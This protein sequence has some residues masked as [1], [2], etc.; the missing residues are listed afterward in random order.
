MGL[1][2]RFQACWPIEK[3]TVELRAEIKGRKYDGAVD[4]DDAIVVKVKADGFIVD[5]MQTIS[6]LISSPYWIAHLSLTFLFF[7]P[8][9]PFHFHAKWIALC[10]SNPSLRIFQI[11]DCF[12]IRCATAKCNKRNKCIHF[13][14]AK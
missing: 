6:Q 1:V 10:K 3:V 11:T 5:N 13:Q 14:P 8:L 7:S 9:C 12:P 4:D 2:T